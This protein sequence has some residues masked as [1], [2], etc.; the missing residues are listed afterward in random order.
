MPSFSG[1]NNM[2]RWFYSL[3]LH[4]LLPLLLLRLYWRGRQAPGY[5]ANPGQRFGFSRNLPSGGIVVHAVSLGETLASQPLV[6]ALLKDYAGLPLIVTNT[7][8]TGAE[9][10]R[11][12]WADRVTQCFLPYDY[13]WAVRRFLDRTRPRLFV[14]M[15]TELWPNLLHELARRQVPVLLAN[16]RLSERSSRGYG[17]ISALT[18]PMLQCLTALAAQDEDTARRFAALGMPESR[19]T[20]TGSLKF[21]L[22][23]PADLPQRVGGLRADWQLAGR[24]V[25]VAASTHEGED[26]VVLEVF[27]QARRRFPNLLLILVPRH[28]ERFERVAELLQKQDCRYVRR[29]LGQAVTTD[30]QVLLGDSLGELLL[31]LGLADVAFVGGSLVP[32]GGHNPL[33]PAALA[34]PV[35]TGPVMFN[36]QQIT[37]TLVQAGALAQA[38]DAF[39]LLARLTEW[40]SAPEQARAAGA[41][42]AAVVAAN[43]GALARH[44]KLVSRLLTEPPAA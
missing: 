3:L 41:A 1:F 28:P 6:N 40:L 38:E 11:V 12:L 31:W 14:V 22:T 9:R 39:S 24:P 2:T 16:A 29:S 43:R 34:V 8:A 27:G 25:W 4:L 10:T 26:A 17:R 30:T 15:E 32:V 37:E 5:R 42:G 19:M 20:V 18:Q 44:L 35:L 21:D 33:E 23:L 13:P 36:F 7:T